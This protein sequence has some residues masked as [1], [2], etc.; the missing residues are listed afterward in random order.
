MRQLREAAAA[1]VDH[2]LQADPGEVQS[3]FDFPEQQPDARP[4]SVPTDPVAL[5]ELHLVA[6]ETGL[7]RRFCK[8]AQGKRARAL[9]P[10]RRG[11]LALQP[12]HG[13]PRS[14]E[15]SGPRPET[16]SPEADQSQRRIWTFPHRRQ[17]QERQP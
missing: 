7:M 15:F 17:N 9:R 2:L 5:V 14:P 13:R 3:T 4:L 6:S 10:N 8:E 16:S 11:Y 1:G 12:Q